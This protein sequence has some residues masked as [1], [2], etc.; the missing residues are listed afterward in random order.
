MFG[1]VLFCMRVSHV[2]VVVVLYVWSCGVLLFV[3]VFVIAWFYRCLMYVLLDL[4][5][6]CLLVFVV[7]CFRCDGWLSLRVLL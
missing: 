5:I 4:F 2:C 7:V 6:V 3:Y 1:H